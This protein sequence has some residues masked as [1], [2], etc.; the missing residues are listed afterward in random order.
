[1]TDYEKLSKLCSY[2][3]R[4]SPWEFELELDDEGWVPVEQLV[5]ALRTE[6]GWA[7]LSADDLAAMIAVAPKQRHELS[8]DRIRARYGHSVPGRVRQEPE[9]EPG[10]LFHGTTRTALA[11][12]R[13]EG[14]LPRQRQ[15]VHLATRPDLAHQIGARRDR[16]PVVLEIDGAAAATAGVLFYR[17]GDDIVL[18]DHVPAA[19][20]TGG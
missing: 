3:L 4:H 5:D 17:A 18:T 1:M 11:A 9:P 10:T 8:E 16:S 13:R 19:F 7:T 14:L 15:Y 6:R 20:I 12:I 2:A